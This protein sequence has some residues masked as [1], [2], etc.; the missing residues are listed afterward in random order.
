MIAPLRMPVEYHEAIPCHDV[1]DTHH[2][3]EVPDHITQALIHG[4]C[5]KLFREQHV[6]NT[7]DKRIVAILG[8]IDAELNSVDW[9]FHNEFLFTITVTS[10]RAHLAGHEAS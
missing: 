9:K 5:G 8:F 3:A 6:L 4:L 10:N 1:T 7:S 2:I